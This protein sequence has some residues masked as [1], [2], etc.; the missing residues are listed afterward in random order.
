M[1]ED[2]RDLPYTEM[3]EMLREAQQQIAEGAAILRFVADETNDGYRGSCLVAH[4]EK[5]VGTGGWCGLESETIEYWI[6]ELGQGT[7]EELSLIHI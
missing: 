4:V 3:I 5:L 2:E 6:E 7:E 1:N